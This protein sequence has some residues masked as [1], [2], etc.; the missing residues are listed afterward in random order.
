MNHHLPGIC[1]ETA[2]FVR[3]VEEGTDETLRAHSLLE[4]KMGTA[5]FKT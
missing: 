5:D 1:S 4:L 3:G 2:A